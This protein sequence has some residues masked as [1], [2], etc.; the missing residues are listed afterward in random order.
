VHTVDIIVVCIAV[1]AVV[2]FAA[3]L[4][5]QRYMLRS[6]GAVP[7]A[8]RRGSRWAYG[9]GRYQDGEFRIYRALGLGT[10]PTNVLR[11]GE[12]V[13]VSRRKP[14]EAERRTLPSSAVVL[15]C[16]SAGSTVVFAIGQSAFTGFVSWLESSAPI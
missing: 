2:S 16:R 7:L 11:R 9:V 10:R 1:A 13:V 5:R 15:N 12:V 14:D 3:V 4:A 6:T 8:V